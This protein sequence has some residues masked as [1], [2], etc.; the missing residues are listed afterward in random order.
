MKHLEYSLNSEHYGEW[1]QESVNK[2]TLPNTQ[3]FQ[4]FQLI[5]FPWKESNAIPTWIN[6]DFLSP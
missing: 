6:F 3:N 2:L 4:I 5:K 1:D